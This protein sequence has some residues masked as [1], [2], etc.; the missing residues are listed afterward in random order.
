MMARLSCREAQ[1]IET[2]SEDVEEFAGATV[3]AEEIWV[4]LRRARRYNSSIM[5][6]LTFSHVP[7]SFPFS[8]CCSGSEVGSCFRQIFGQRSTSSFPSF[9]S[10]FLHVHVI[11]ITYCQRACSVSIN[12]QLVH[13][14]YHTLRL[15]L[16]LQSTGAE[17]RALAASDMPPSCSRPAATKLY[18]S[19]A[20][21]VAPHR[22]E[23]Q[24]DAA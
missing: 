9:P 3:P 22:T 1:T 20:V 21:P 15:T 14:F 18:W 8:R 6:A 11:F 13:D 16:H 24:P 12:S 5:L 23:L 4:D 2:G 19:F 10:P 7:K 17:V